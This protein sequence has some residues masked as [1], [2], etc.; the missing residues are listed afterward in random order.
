MEKVQKPSNSMDVSVSFSLSV[1]LKNMSTGILPTCI[2]TLV[3]TQFSLA[4]PLKNP[5]TNALVL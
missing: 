1:P 2:L 5:F 4:F 3:F